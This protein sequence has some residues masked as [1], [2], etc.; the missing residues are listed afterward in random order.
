MGYTNTVYGDVH[1]AGLT[2]AE[3]Q[4]LIDRGEITISLARLLQEYGGGHFKEVGEMTSFDLTDLAEAM[5]ETLDRQPPLPIAAYKNPK[6]PFSVLCQLK[7]EGQ[8]QTW[9]GPGLCPQVRQRMVHAISLLHKLSAV[10][11]SIVSHG[12]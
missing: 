12:W 1:L 10:D 3:G 11:A 8:V 4:L 5:E 6:D 9:N 2:E 7:M